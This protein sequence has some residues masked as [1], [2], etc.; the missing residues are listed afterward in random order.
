[1]EWHNIGFLLLGRNKSTTRTNLR[2][3][4]SSNKIHKGEG[5]KT[6]TTVSDHNVTN[7]DA[8]KDTLVHILRT[9]IA[10]SKTTTLLSLYIILQGNAH[11]SQF[12]KDLIR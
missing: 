1:M 5:V 8:D 6:K 2:H 4:N 7:F 11:I 10:L 3:Y 9:L 12:N